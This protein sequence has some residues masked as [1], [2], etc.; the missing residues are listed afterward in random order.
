[1]TQTAELEHVKTS[2][3]TLVEDFVKERY[4]SGNVQ[5]YMRELHNY[6]FDRAHIAPASPDRILRQ[7]RREGKFDYTVIDRRASKYQLTPLSE[8]RPSVKTSTVTLLYQGKPIDRFPVS[9]RRFKLPRHVID[10][11]FSSN[12][13]ELQV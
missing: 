4:A 13:F 7:L 5:F 10:H 3:R 8:S 11:I 9:G 1:M 12:D 2:I 6:I